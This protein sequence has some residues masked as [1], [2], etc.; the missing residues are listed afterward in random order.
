M[1]M[2][3]L[4]CLITALFVFTAAFIISMAWL[5]FH[6]EKKSTPGI[7][8]ASAETTTS[9]KSGLDKNPCLLPGYLQPFDLVNLERSEFLQDYMQYLHDPEGKHTYATALSDNGWL[10][11]TRPRFGYLNHPLW[12]LICIT[13][14]DSVARTVILYNQRP[15][16][17][18][19]KIVILE[20][21]EVIRTSET[22][23]LKPCSSENDIVHRLNNIAVTLQPGKT[24]TVITCINTLGVIEA[25]WRACTRAEFSRESHRLTIILGLYCGIVLAL[26][27]N[28]FISWFALRKPQF[29]F[30]VGYA[31]SFLLYM[32]PINGITR[33]INFGLPPSFWKVGVPIAFFFTFLFWIH[34]TKFFLNTSQTMPFINKLL[35]IL[36]LP[37]ATGILLYIFSLQFPTIYTFLP[38]WSIFA[39]T[40]YI[41]I[42]ITGILGVHR[43]LNHSR[44]FFLGHVTIFTM[45]GILAVLMQES[46]IKNLNI[47]LMIH[48][49]AVTIHVIVMS[50]S[51][52]LLARESQKQLAINEEKL[53]ESSRFAEIGRTV[54]MIVHQWR[55]PLSRLGTQLTELYAIIENKIITSM[56]HDKVG[57]TALTDNSKH[58]EHIR[59][60]LNELLPEM[61]Y[62]I[63][64]MNRTVDDFTDIFSPKTEVQTFSPHQEVEKALTMLVKRINEI[65]VTIERKNSTAPTKD[66]ESFF[67]LGHPT[68]L[69]H[70]ITVII[71]NA[72]DEFEKNS[73]KK[74]EKPKITIGLQIETYQQKV[75]SIIIE[76]NAGGIDMNLSE[77][78]INRPFVGDKGSK[79]MGLGLSIAVKLVEDRMKGNIEMK[80]SGKGACFIIHLPV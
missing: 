26:T 58:R 49:M 46:M 40:L 52:G 62:G 24:I 16:L 28:A 31:I 50:F 53:Q 10:P 17:Q 5:I 7:A 56:G 12:T 25:G 23:F 27:V 32:A 33:I 43:R 60:L 45:S 79:H 77:K 51:L 80:N 61:D 65:G 48:P 78:R 75:L 68:A 39:I 70:V 64:A 76:D 3:P 19:M 30:L 21:G 11:L 37:F 66:S 55:T 67:M 35:N 63:K 9:E 71:E 2:K 4:F 8:K 69:V 20:N 1:K 18:Y 38:L 29:G 14:S 41:T 47:L 72:L 34:F 6:N 73:M 13:N 15:M 57:N 36:Q 42:I 22:G 74:E 59:Y 44:L 54:G